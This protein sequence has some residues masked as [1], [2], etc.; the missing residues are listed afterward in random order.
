MFH[1]FLARNAPVISQIQAVYA[2]M[3]DFFPFET[4]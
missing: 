4:Y 1:D 2:N 3:T